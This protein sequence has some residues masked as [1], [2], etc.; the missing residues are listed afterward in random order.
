MKYGGFFLWRP[1]LE[2]MP[3]VEG[4]EEGRRRLEPPPLLLRSIRRV[5]G[6]LRFEA[7]TPASLRQRGRRWKPAGGLL[8]DH[9]TNT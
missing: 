2:K 9:D 4:S 1:V 5:G 8:P 3:N 6:T 7:A